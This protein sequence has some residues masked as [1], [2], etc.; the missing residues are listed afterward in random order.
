MATAVIMVGQNAGM[1]LGPIIFGT[2][3]QAVGWPAAIAGLAVR[4]ALG[5]LAG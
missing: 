5:L 1:L 4:C 2:L 3:A